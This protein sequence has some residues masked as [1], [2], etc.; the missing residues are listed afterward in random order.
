[1]DESSLGSRKATVFLCHTQ[2]RPRHKLCSSHPQN[3][4]LSSQLKKMTLTDRHHLNELKSSTNLISHYP[5]C[6]ATIVRASTAAAP[7]FSSQRHEQGLESSSRTSC[8]M[9]RSMG[10][11]LRLATSKIIS[12]M[13]P[14][15]SSSNKRL[16]HVADTDRARMSSHRC[17]S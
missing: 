10:N 15:A 2:P 5:R 8:S 13:Q 12:K 4:L 7:A 6:P 3:E 16:P 1:M 9:R 11:V 14:C 17:L